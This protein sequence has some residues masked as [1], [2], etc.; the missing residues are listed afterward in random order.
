[1][2]GE[3]VRMNGDENNGLV[4]AIEDDLD[5]LLLTIEKVGKS[6]NSRR[7][8][9]ILCTPDSP[10][11]E[12]NHFPT[13]NIES[14]R[15]DTSSANY[16]NF[17]P[18]SER[19]N[20]VNAVNGAQRKPAINNE[21]VAE[22]DFSHY[23]DFPLNMTSNNDTW[24]VNH[25]MDYDAQ[26][27]PLP[28]KLGHLPKQSLS[29]KNEVNF[30]SPD[31]LS[32]KTVSSNSSFS[33]ILLQSSLVETRVADVCGSFTDR[34][35]DVEDDLI[36]PASSTNGPIN[37]GMHS[38]NKTS[39]LHFNSEHKH[40]QV[41]GWTNHS[42]FNAPVTNTSSNCNIPQIN[43]S[44]YGGIA[45]HSPDLP[46]KV[47]KPGKFPTSITLTTST[48][49]LSHN[50]T[51]SSRDYNQINCTGPY[52]N[53]APQ[54]NSKPILPRAA[55]SKSAIALATQQL[56]LKHQELL[57][58]RRGKVKSRSSSAPSSP[59]MPRKLIP[60]NGQHSK[61]RRGRVTTRSTTGSRVRNTST[62]SL[63]AR[64][65]S[66]SKSEI[67]GSTSNH[68]LRSFSS[69][70]LPGTINGSLK[71]TLSVTSLRSRRRG[72]NLS[73]SSLDSEC[74]EDELRE[75]HDDA[76]KERKKD[77]EAAAVEKARLQCI[78]DMC[79]DFI[80]NT[81]KKDEP[82]SED[83]SKSEPQPS[84]QPCTYRRLA[85]FEGDIWKQPLSGS[86]VFTNS[87]ESSSDELTQR[88]LRACE[89]A[90]RTLRAE[91][92]ILGANKERHLP[93]ADVVEIQKLR[94]EG[95]S[96]IED[97]QRRISE[98]ETQL[99]EC[100][101]EL[102]MERALIE[103]ELTSEKSNLVSDERACEELKD[104]IINLEEEYMTQREKH[105]AIVDKEKKKLV[106]IQ[107]KVSETRKQMDKCPESMRGSIEGMLIKEQEE[108]DQESRRFEDAEFNSLETLS[109]LD[110]E[111][112]VM[113]KSLIRRK[114]KLEMQIENRKARVS[115]LDQQLQD[116]TEQQ[117]LENQRLNNERDSAIGS[118]QEQREETTLLERKYHQLTGEFPPS[119][120]TPASI[121]RSHRRIPSSTSDLQPPDIFKRQI[122]TGSSNFETK[123][124][125]F[126]NSD[127][128][129]NAVKSESHTRN[130]SIQSED[131]SATK[132]P[133]KLGGA[134][135]N[136]DSVL[137]FRPRS[138]NLANSKKITSHYSTLRKTL[139]KDSSSP[140]SI[141]DDDD[142]MVALQNRI[143]ESRSLH[144]SPSPVT[145]SL[146]N[147]RQ[148]LNSSVPPSY[149]RLNS[150]SG[151][152][153]AQSGD[154][155][156]DTTSISSMDSMD[157]TLSAW[158]IQSPESH[159][160]ERLFEMERLIAD[161]TAEKK[162]LLAEVKGL[163]MM[164]TAERPNHE[165]ETNSPDADDITQ[166]KLR[167]SNGDRRQARPMTRYL[168]VRASDFNLRQ[169][170]ESC[171]HNP[172]A[173]RHTSINATSCRGYMTK[174][175]GRIKT[176]RKRW[177]VFDRM[178]KSL[179]YYS[180][181]HE[182]KLKGMIYF[183]AI[184]DVFFDH[185]K[186]HKSPNPS[187][188]FC[189]KCYDRV[190]YL[191]APSSEAM[192]IWMD[193]LVTGAEGY[194]EYMKTFE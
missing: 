123:M 175:G 169:H 189:V 62:S 190:Y 124:F 172:S 153:R 127:V 111:K 165:M 93:V 41:K 134:T 35:L 25:S 173:C 171:G 115:T 91:E 80:D 5:N 140:L 143:R 176:W 52:D 53:L 168:P 19:G 97:I 110:E 70:T 122:S 65:P 139:R 183:Q 170:I 141:K 145:A 83:K 68:H 138:K 36:S 150:N 144:T 59:T 78:L 88:T 49:S 120:D 156:K 159:D 11:N 47:Q 26:K 32:S 154:K 33:P 43:I 38:G 64:S 58:L 177:F 188:T 45:T 89:D 174:M 162:R 73:L 125:N 63:R 146:L 2:K 7:S 56:R 136:D 135:Y 67:L 10:T 109:R 179:S 193:T 130:T 18:F 92:N 103:G 14:K 6:L 22:N 112:E 23:F 126:S 104:Q 148:K 137:T 4:K 116:L 46:K 181:K 158:S 24:F 95:L 107:K 82:K 21:G 30:I 119:L 121:A 113:Q 3:T 132:S 147:S 164:Q 152:T 72:S 191:V 42:G 60:G 84:K 8:S 185:L 131:K 74:I 101:S 55:S 106:D 16:C 117:N 151:H 108:L 28:P 96:R 149:Q 180:D 155:W 81:M 76:V 128:F 69:S 187:L 44:S 166:V 142:Q 39:D 17:K 160:M 66:P 20:Q 57:A 9:L 178:K 85:S 194:R 157:T 102:D 87:V 34:E 54:P 167:S 12:E 105:Q 1:M 184:E 133:V 161:A 27:P 90:D 94:E 40:S 77:Q 31:R 114:K 129:S 71:K 192:R 15:V 61:D 86:R 51:P 163:P 182:V 75:I 50:T 48:S 100:T 37:H 118:L 98:L 99:S 13:S 186:S 79:A 29:N